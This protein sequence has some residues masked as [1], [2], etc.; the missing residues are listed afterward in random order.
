MEDSFDEFMSPALDKFDSFDGKLS[1]PLKSPEASPKPRPKSEGKISKRSRNENSLRELTKRFITLII[2]AEGMVLD[3]NDAMSILKVQKRRIYD[4]TNVL[5]GIG[6][7]EKCG[8]NKIHWKSMLMPS[9][10]KEEDDKTMEK[11]L[12]EQLEIEKCEEEL[13]KMFSNLTESEEFKK[14]AYVTYDDVLGML[15]DE[16]KNMSSILITAPKGSTVSFPVPS[17]VE[18]H[19]QECK[20][21]DPVLEGRKYQAH[22]TTKEGEIAVYGIKGDDPNEFLNLLSDEESIAD[23]SEDDSMEDSISLMEDLSISDDQSLEAGECDTQP[24]TC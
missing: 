18:K 24:D 21:I 13:D 5:E 1:S 17:E 11:L 16:R 22:I 10:E 4:I 15:E 3:L 20:G 9:T 23:L 8:K 6:L 12:N 14:Y 7:I 19:I 2:S